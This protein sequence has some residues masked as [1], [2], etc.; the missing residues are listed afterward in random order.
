LAVNGEERDVSTENPGSVTGWI[1]RLKQGDESA[2][3]ALWTRYFRRLVRLARSRLPSR[4]RTTAD[5][6]DVALSAFHCLY[7]S[8]SRGRVPDLEDRDD[9]WRLL[10]TITMHKAM[11]QNR[12]LGRRK[13]GGRCEPIA[14]DPDQIASSEPDAEL[15]ACLAE[16]FERLIN[17]LGDSTLRRIALWKVEGFTNEEIASQLGSG[18]RTVERKLAVI[19]ATWIEEKPD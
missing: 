7:R 10:A 16:Q 19:R 2:A 4:S 13:R 12:R 17:Q 9:L 5:E 18:L 3:R 8:M 11:D 15:S 14:A 6:E 1:G